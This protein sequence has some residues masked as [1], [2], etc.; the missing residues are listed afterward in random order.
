MYFPNG[1]SLAGLGAL[2]P[3]GRWRAGHGFAPDDFLAVYSGNLGVK[4]GLDILLAA[5]PLVAN[6]QVRIV[7]CGQGAAGARL[8]EEADRLGRPNLT[9]LPLQDDEAYR[10]MM[11]DTNLALIT[12]QAGTGQYFFPSKLLSA[13]ACA[14]PVLAVADGDSELALA[15]GEG[16]FGLRTPAGDAAALAGALDRAA[17][18]DNAE[19]RAWGEAG[20]KYVERFEW[21]N[22]LAEFERTLSAIRH[23]D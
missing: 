10:E 4:Q 20:R 9:L 7:I 23:D 17:A 16:G 13:L 3:R 5:A 2:P 21:A 6:R 18:M 14:R 19:L 15:L 12:Q 11:A 22:V 1:A 8:Q